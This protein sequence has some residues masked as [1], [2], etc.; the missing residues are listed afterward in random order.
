MIIVKIKERSFAARLAAFALKSSAAAIV[1][2]NT[3]HLWN[4]S[5]A[6]F[7]AN[8]RWVLHELEHVFQYRRLGFIR[9]LLMYVWESLRKG[10]SRNRFEAEARRAESGKIEYNSVMFI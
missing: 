5:K 2:G 10:Y 3:V 9:F 6:S 7:L 1:F 8:E 4:V